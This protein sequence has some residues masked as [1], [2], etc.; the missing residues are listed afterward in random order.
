MPRDGEDASAGA[1]DRRRVEHMLRCCRDAQAIVGA[2]PSEDVAADM[3]RTRALVNCFTEIGEAAARLSPSG[4]T[5][6]GSLPWRQIVGMRNIV[7]HV[8]WG[9]D[10]STLVKTAQSELPEVIAALETA[11]ATWVAEHE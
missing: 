4:R 2:S 8:Y 1:H 11:L 7:V 3:I 10:V 5:R 9:I 6:V